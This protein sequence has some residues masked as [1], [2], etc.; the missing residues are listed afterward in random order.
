MKVL[1]KLVY[2]LL[3]VNSMHSVQHFLEGHA[4]LFCLTQ[5]TCNQNKLMAGIG[6]WIQK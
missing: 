1:L 5:S 3:Q 2:C 6:V 4:P